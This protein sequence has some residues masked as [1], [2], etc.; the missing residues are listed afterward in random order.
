MPPENEDVLQKLAPSIVEII[1]DTEGEEQDSTT[2]GTGFVVTDDGLVVTC[3]HVITDSEEKLRNTIKARFYSDFI[4]A[5]SDNRGINIETIPKYS[6]RL[7][8]EY[9]KDP[10]VDLAFLKLDL[11][12]L[13]EQNKKLAPV[14][15]DDKVITLNDF[16]SV[17]FKKAHMFAGLSAYGTVGIPTRKKTKEGLL[18]PQIIELHHNKKIQPGMS[19]AP[20]FDKKRSRVVG[21]ITERY[22]PVDYNDEEFA[23]ALPVKSMIDVC[24]VLREKNQGLTVL[25]K[26]LNAIGEK[27]ESSIYRWIDEV[28]VPPNEYDEIRGALKR[29]RIVFITGT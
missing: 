9:T 26:F 21:I 15:L 24:P 8:E 4:N 29:D 13:P 28:Y 22:N 7:V 25:S 6:M 12:P 10:S 16:A 18:S 20:V 19:G 3:R 27:V 17:G 2:L 11:T 23:L 5:T 14:E 1:S